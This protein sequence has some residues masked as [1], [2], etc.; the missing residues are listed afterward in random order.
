LDQIWVLNRFDYNIIRGKNKKKVYMLESAGLGCDLN[1]F[2]INNFTLQYLNIRKEL[3]ISEKQFVIT[4]TGRFV[5]F[6][7][8]DLVVR[9]FLE[10]NKRYPSVYKLVLIGGN[11]P[12]HQTGLTDLEEKEFSSCQEIVKVGFTDRV[13][14]YLSV[15]DIFLFPSLKEGMPVC[16]IEALAMGIPVI[17]TD[18]RGCNDLVKN[19]LNGILLSNKPTIEQIIGAISLLRNSPDLMSR[20]KNNA[21][22]NRSMLSRQVYISKQIEVY[23][24]LI[25][26]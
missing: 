12:I 26:I 3:N 5:N 11:D 14:R 2:N 16:I 24:N 25:P 23:Y 7:G 20:L 15:S 19:N 1:R 8:F 6:K 10:L 18:S 22:K 9:S 17:T 4:Y 13:E 21:I